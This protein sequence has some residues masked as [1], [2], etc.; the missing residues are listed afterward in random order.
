MLVSFCVKCFNQEAYIKE[1]LEGAFAQAY[2]PLEIVISDDA[3]TDGSTA[4]IEHAIAEGTA[5]HPDIKVIFHRNEK[6]LGNLGNWLKLVSL[7]HGELL[8]KADGDDVSLPERAACLVAALQNGGENC[9]IVYSNAVKVDVQGNECGDVRK[10]VFERQLPLGAVMACRRECAIGFMEHAGS[11]AFDDIVT[12]GR[13]KILGL[14][15][16]RI[17]R[18]LV[19]YRVG[20][21]ASN[22]GRRS[23]SDVMARTLRIEEASSACLIEDLGTVCSQIPAARFET[24]RAEF[25]SRLW[26][27]RQT[28]ELW[29]YGPFGKRLC[30]F[31][32]LHRG[33]RLSKNF[34][35]HG[36][37][38]SPKALSAPLLDFLYRHGRRK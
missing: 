7:S 16:I 1:A 32:S 20:V 2:R 17:D 19:R 28:L 22:V 36:I 34:C 31:L 23:Y 3:S 25:E 13:A 10:E 12:S 35:I 8:V 38:I 37:L 24:L 26:T 15:E 21:G 18:K 27:D 14:S 5:V 33:C 29:G 30:A 6:N 4:V 9:G 11:L